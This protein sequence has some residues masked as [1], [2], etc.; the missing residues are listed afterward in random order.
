MNESWVK[1][2]EHPDLREGLTLW[3]SPLCTHCPRKPLV[4]CDIC[5][6]QRLHSVLNILSVHVVNLVDVTF[7]VEGNMFKL[8]CM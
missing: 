2:T 8:G 7:P 6:V 3:F 1:A 4:L 5:D